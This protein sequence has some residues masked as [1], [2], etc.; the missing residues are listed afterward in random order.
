MQCCLRETVA[1]AE[2]SKSGPGAT[3][4]LGFRWPRLVDPGPEIKREDG[5]DRTVWGPGRLIALPGFEM[6]LL[7]QRR[8]CWLSESPTRTTSPILDFGRAVTRF[9]AASIHGR[10]E[11][12]ELA[13]SPAP[14]AH[15][16]PSANDALMPRRQRRHEDRT[17]ICFEAAGAQ[18]GRGP[19]RPSA[20]PLVEDAARRIPSPWPLASACR[21]THAR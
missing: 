1:T 15:M 9:G 8:M 6:R 17:L 16:L 21:S 20:I 18:S 13:S 5:I 7:L 19:R 14:R 11:S 10:G 2:A 4:D 12:R 3:G